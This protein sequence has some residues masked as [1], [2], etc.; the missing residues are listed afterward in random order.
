MQGT[1]RSPP[2]CPPGPPS[3]ISSNPKA[4]A[5]LGSNLKQSTS[6]KHAPTPAHRQRV[7]QALRAAVPQTQRHQ[8]T[9]ARQLAQRIPRQLLSRKVQLG[10]LQ[11]MRGVCDGQDVWARSGVAGGFERE[12]ILVGH[13]GQCAR[14]APPA[15][16]SLRARC[17]C[18]PWGEG[19]G[20]QAPGRGLSGRGKDWGAGSFGMGGRVWWNS[21]DSGCKAGF[22]LNEGLV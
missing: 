18:I 5:G 8:R 13:M 9:Q 11:P 19:A 22:G 12:R 10:Q 4:A 14:R 20:A 7:S 2:A 15:V 17:S 6:Q 16:S 3:S 1:T 21:V